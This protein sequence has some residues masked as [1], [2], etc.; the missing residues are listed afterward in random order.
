MEEVKLKIEA[1][2]KNYLSNPTHITAEDGIFGETK[3]RL[4]AVP[5]L[6]ED[7]TEEAIKIANEYLE[8]NDD[9]QKE[10]EL[11]DFIQKLVLKH[12]QEIILGKSN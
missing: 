11:V 2:I 9:K 6:M 1:A 8:K 10:E 3:A 12:S 5:K 7:A 4:K